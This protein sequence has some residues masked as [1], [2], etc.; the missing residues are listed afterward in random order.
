M[1]V[2]TLVA[3]AIGL[4]S[5]MNNFGMQA[6]SM[7][8]Q[9]FGGYGWMPSNN[10]TDDDRADIKQ[11]MLVFR[12]AQRN[13]TRDF[14]QQICEQY[15]LSCPGSP[16]SNLT[17]EDRAEVQQLIEEFQQAQRNETQEFYNAQKQEAEEFWQQICDQY[18]ITCPNGT[19]FICGGGYG[20]RGNMSLPKQGYGPVFGGWP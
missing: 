16:L 6:P 7:G 15:N 3:G 2:L 9:R 1:L 12:Q 10:L 14:Q 19:Q 17:D 20:F 5:A 13:V 4:V 8:H 18:N 11:Q